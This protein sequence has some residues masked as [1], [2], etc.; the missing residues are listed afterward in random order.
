M[1]CLPSFCAA[2]IG[3]GVRGKSCWIFSRGDFTVREGDSLAIDAQ[4]APREWESRRGPTPAVVEGESEAE[5]ALRLGTG[6]ARD[7]G[8]PNSLSGSDL[9]EKKEWS[10]EF[11]S[12]NPGADSGTPGG[13]EPVL[14][15]SGSRWFEVWT[16]RRLFPP[17]D[18]KR[19][20]GRR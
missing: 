5:S 3:E 10:R 17:H 13:A 9:S 20:G 8:S 15:Q 11:P 6:T 14:L 1:I 16:S 7:W 4:L 12:K 18:E 2:K 19:G